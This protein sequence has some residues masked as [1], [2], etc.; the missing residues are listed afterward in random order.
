M[1]NIKRQMRNTVWSSVKINYSPQHQRVSLEMET[2]I[3]KS[4]TRL[5]VSWSFIHCALI[6]LSLTLDLHILSSL[7]ICQDL[8]QILLLPQ[9]SNLKPIFL[10]PCTLVIPSLSLSSLHHNILMQVLLCLGPW[11]TIFIPHSIL[12]A[13]PT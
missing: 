1:A 9:I 3:V 4:N 11:W 5:I 12:F 10:P 8:S 2:D 6:W 13:V 7:P